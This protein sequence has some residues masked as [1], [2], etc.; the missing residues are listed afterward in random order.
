MR[1][2]ERTVL[3]LYVLLA[4]LAVPVFPHFLSPNEFSRWA[5]AAS[6]VENGTPEISRVLPLLGPSFEDAS[7]KDGRVYSNKAPGAALVS[8]P[9]YLLA[10]PFAG[11]PSAASMRPVLW[12][13][14]LFGATLPAALLALV[15]FRSAVL[16]GAPPARARFAMFALVFATPLFA[17]GLLLFSHALVAACLF[18][19]WAALFLPRDPP[20]AFRRD[21]AGGALIGLAVFSEYPAA[22]PAAVLFLCAAIPAPRRALA[23]T[24]GGAPFAIALLGYNSICFGGMFEL[25]S[26]HE[27]QA[28]FHA[29][30]STG[31]FGFSLPSPEFLLRLLADP[32]KGLL[33]FSPFLLLWPGAF[34]A[35]RDVLPRDARLALVLAP[36]SLLLLFAGFP[37]WHG[38]FTVGPRYLVAALPFLVFPFVFGKGGILESALVGAS[39]L[40]VCATTL[41]FPFVPPGF[42]MPWGS[43]AGFFFE[44]GLTSP[45]LLHLVSPMAARF[46]LPTIVCVAVILFLDERRE[47]KIFLEGKREEKS[48]G[49]WRSALAFFC[50]A[51]ACAVLGFFLSKQVFLPSS[52]LLLQRAYVAD[53]YFERQGTLEEEIAR[54]GVPQPRLLARRER[55]VTL[56]PTSWPFAE[57]SR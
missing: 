49:R 11:P 10:R 12:A 55:E 26:A 52:S 9:G 25:S 37:S 45:N 1:T 30:L 17:Y 40:A 14:R 22:M 7:V 27:R 20:R 38:G 56:P 4:L 31:L 21:I 41:A 46:V 6:L 18:G 13:M 3:G 53:V 43:F 24:A 19:A 39:T 34:R 16:L 2:R 8:L 54:T 23:V 42:A 5:F 48:D 32:S 29:L 35:S 28:S 36:L 33:V 15:L 44:R 47:E 50:G 57:A 51:A